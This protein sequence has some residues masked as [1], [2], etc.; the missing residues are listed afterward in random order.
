LSR[1]DGTKKPSYD[2]LA[3]LIKKEWWVPPTEMRTDENGTVVVHGF[4]GDYTVAGE[5]VALRPGE[6]EASVRLPR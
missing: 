3:G 6:P 1:S 5:A 2:A 4:Y